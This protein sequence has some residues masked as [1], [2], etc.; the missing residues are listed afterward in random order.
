MN[1]EELIGRREGWFE[2]GLREGPVISSRARLA[3]NLKGER[4][5]DWAGEKNRVRLWGGLREL[6][7]SHEWIAGA[8]AWEMGELDDVDRELL[9]ER[10]LISRE[11]VARAA[12]SGVLISPDE[13][14]SV[15]INEEDHLRMQVIRPG[16]ALH[17]VWREVNELDDG[18]EGEVTYAFS[19]KLGYLTACPSN[20]GTGIRVSVMLHLP[21]L[22][23]MEE[24]NPVLK[25]VSR[26]GL[27]VRGL[28]GEGTESAG[29]MFQI[30]NQITLG[31]RE[32]DIV[33]HLEQI[34]LELVEHEENARKRLFET[35]ETVLEDHIGRAYGILSHARI[36]GSKEA[37]DLLSAL[38]LGCDL[39]MIDYA[40]REQ[41][42]RLL[43]HTQPAHLQ[44]I[45]KQT[46]PSGERDRVRA[47]LIRSML[48]G[49]EQT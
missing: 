8:A 9:Y 19:P 37:L 36:L 27:A 47:G 49:E 43:V 13:R 45:E 22:V 30:S 34:T 31:K 7:L 3:R 38:R 16:I 39:G 25:G 10:H 40:R 29:H 12:G 28:W 41:I 18:V 1:P 42:D 21:G 11:Q 46:L 6:F 2:T 20:V 44:R 17:E 48:R 14:T 24:M 15:M 35:R 4:F 26:I 23:L 32:E 33:D 5:P